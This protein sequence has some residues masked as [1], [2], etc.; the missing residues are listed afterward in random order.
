MYLPARAC[1]A[2]AGNPFGPV[3]A[4]V[5]PSLNK[6]MREARLLRQIHIPSPSIR[7]E[8]KDG[9]S[10]RQPIFPRPRSRLSVPGPFILRLRAADGLEAAL[11]TMRIG[12]LVC[13]NVSQSLSFVEGDARRTMA[14]AGAGASERSFL[15]SCH[16]D[17]PA[18]RQGI[19]HARHEHW[20]WCRRIMAPTA[21]P[22]RRSRPC[23][24]P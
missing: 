7:E 23:R 18:S 8:Y 9:S 22:V 16:C 6:R 17:S 4:V 19:K 3:P 11:G 12:R 5:E 14:P 21:T 10:A 15:V 2:N 1:L 24:Y 20:T 13:M